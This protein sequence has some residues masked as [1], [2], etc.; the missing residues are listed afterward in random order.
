VTSA[1]PGGLG[2]AF[3]PDLCRTVSRLQRDPDT[4]A[5]RVE[6]RESVGGFVDRIARRR[7]QSARRLRR[8]PLR[9]VL[10]P[11]IR[12]CFGYGAAC[13]WLAIDCVIEKRAD[14]V[15]WQ[16]RQ[17]NRHGHGQRTLSLRQRG[18]CS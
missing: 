11:Q 9:R 12:D 18:A 2:G 10:W 7:L 14:A 15:R 3:R 5:V 16:I 4:E 1:D 6:F 8:R 17:R 13:R